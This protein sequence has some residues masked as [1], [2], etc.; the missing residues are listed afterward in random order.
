[1]SFDFFAKSDVVFEVRSYCRYGIFADSDSEIKLDGHAAVDASSPD[2]RYYDEDGNRLKAIGVALVLNPDATPPTRLF[3]FEELVPAPTP[4]V[5]PTPGPWVQKS[6]SRTV[7]EGAQ[8]YSIDHCRDEGVF[9]YELNYSVSTGMLDAVRLDS[10]VI[11]G[12]ASGTYWDDIG[13]FS[14]EDLAKVKHGFRV[15]HLSVDHENANI[16]AVSLGLVGG[17]G[18]W[19]NGKDGQWSEEL[20]DVAFK[21]VEK[22]IIPGLEEHMIPSIWNELDELA[23]N[24]FKIKSS[25]KWNQQ[26]ITFADPI[27]ELG[28]DK[29]IRIEFT[30]TTYT[31]PAIKPGVTVLEARQRFWESKKG[32]LELSDLSWYEAELLLA[33]A[34][35]SVLIDITGAYSKIVNIEVKVD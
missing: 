23:E 21:Y 9:E 4:T 20:Y 19:P 26:I 30:Y 17:G 3:S 16:P 28:D 14:P 7:Y 29:V 12:R 10:L 34:E 32:A 33:L 27:I 18:C 13:I 11:T 22:N 2:C 24:W 35:S 25:P 15:T 8:A 6:I 31:N 5:T 1:M